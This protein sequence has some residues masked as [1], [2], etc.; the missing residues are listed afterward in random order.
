MHIPPFK[1]CSLIPL[2]CSSYCPTIFL[3]LQ[4]FKKYYLYSQLYPLCS[5]CLEPVSPVCLYFPHPV[6][7]DFITVTE[8]NYTAKYHITSNSSY[9]WIYLQQMMC[10]TGLLSSSWNIIWISPIY[11]LFAHFVS[12]ALAKITI[13]NFVC[14]LELYAYQ[15]FSKIG[16][17]VT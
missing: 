4:H 1:K 8:D 16:K 6:E 9:Y 11:F 3:S 14:S 10:P 2:S 5:V 13:A 15:Y 12:L 17:Y 7:I